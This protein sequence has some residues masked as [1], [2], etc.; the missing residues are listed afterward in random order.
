M[1]R[2]INLVCTFLMTSPYRYNIL[3]GNRARLRYARSRLELAAEL[4]LFFFLACATVLLGMV[5][6]MRLIW[7]SLFAGPRLA[8]RFLSHPLTVVGEAC[9]FLHLCYLYWRLASGYVRS[10]LGRSLCQ[11]ERSLQSGCSRKWEEGTA[12]CL[13]ASLAFRIGHAP[14][15]DDILSRNAFAVA[16]SLLCL[17][18]VTTPYEVMGLWPNVPHLCVLAGLHGRCMMLCRVAISIALVLCDVLWLKQT[19]PQVVSM[20]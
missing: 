6:A 8:M 19:S 18:C 3:S 9:D 13:C 4:S 7:L 10:P 11:R 1:F 16:A 14:A 17:P 5:G 20:F 12:C 2:C 15:C